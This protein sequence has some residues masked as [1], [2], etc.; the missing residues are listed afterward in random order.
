MLTQATCQPTMK[1]QTTVQELTNRSLKFASPKASA[2]G[3]VSSVKDNLM[4]NQGG[5]QSGIVLTDQSEG[6]ASV[7][8]SKITGLPIPHITSI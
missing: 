7:V 2:L 3:S 8:K 4:A 5:Q 1:N 6:L